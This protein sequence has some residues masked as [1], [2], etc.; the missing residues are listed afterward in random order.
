MHHFFIVPLEVADE[1]EVDAKE[2]LWI[3][4]IGGHVYNRR[5]HT[6]AQPAADEAL[7]FIKP[8]PLPRGELA[9][10]TKRYIQ[11]RSPPL[12]GMLNLWTRSTDRRP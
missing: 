6:L 11:M 5:R 1:C 3:S 4:R 8:Q 10:F 9:H 7:F 12:P 2:H